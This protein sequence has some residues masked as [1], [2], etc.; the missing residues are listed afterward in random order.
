[1]AAEVLE[2]VT[3]TGGRRRHPIVVEPPDRPVYAPAR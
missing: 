1:M 2:S 3:N